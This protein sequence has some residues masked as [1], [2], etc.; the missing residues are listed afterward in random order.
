MPVNVNGKDLECPDCS[1]TERI[2][3][4]G[5]DSTGGTATCMDCGCQFQF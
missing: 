3:I 2:S 1:N 4:S 5:M